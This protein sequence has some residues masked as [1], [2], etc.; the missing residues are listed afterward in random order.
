MNIPE[1]VFLLHEV[2]GGNDVLKKVLREGIGQPNPD[3]IKK[4]IYFRPPENFI[5][6]EYSKLKSDEERIH[7]LFPR[8]FN[9]DYAKTF[10]NSC[11]VFIKVKT[12]GIQLVNWHANDT[13]RTNFSRSMLEW[14]VEINNKPPTNNM[15]PSSSEFV[16]RY[17]WEVVFSPGDRF[18]I[19]PAKK[20]MFFLPS[21]PDRHLFRNDK[22]KMDE[23]GVTRYGVCARCGGHVHSL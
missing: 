10:G 14:L 19:F 1:F 21:G 5:S 15:E 17:S 23:A 4:G 7:H 8:H 3:K 18:F 20:I 12:L 9:P 22:Y 2:K 16:S 11:Y 13:H 6:K